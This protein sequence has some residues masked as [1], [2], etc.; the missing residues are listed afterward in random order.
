MTHSVRLIGITKPVIDDVPD[1]AAL[2]AFCARV[3]STANQSNHATGPKL[4]R[5]LIKRQEWSPLEMVSLTIE[6][7]TTRDIARQIL[8]HRS[9]SFQEFSQRYAEV[10]A[11]PVIREARLQDHKDRQNSIEMED[12]SLIGLLWEHEQRVAN[13]AA[14]KAYQWALDNGVAKEVARA[15]LPEGLTESRLYMAGSLRSWLHYVKL[16]NDVK[17]QKEHRII[18]A[19]VAAILAEQFPD[20][21]EYFTDE[22]LNAGQ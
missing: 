20:L 14:R 7:V 17:T 9:F 22:T 11:P 1:T 2:L 19:D 6:I 13:E 4:L 12:D 15:V 16:R 18:A 5:S 8:R 10:T 21:A 3:S